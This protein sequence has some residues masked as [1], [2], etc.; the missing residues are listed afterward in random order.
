MAMQEGLFTLSKQ[1][2]HM[3]VGGQGGK[4]KGHH[5]YNISHLF[6]GRQGKE[7][8]PWRHSAPF[9]GQSF[10]LLPMRTLPFPSPRGTTYLR[11]PDHP[12]ACPVLPPWKMWKPL[13]AAELLHPPLLVS[14]LSTAHTSD[15]QTHLMLCSAANRSSRQAAE[16]G[17]AEQ[18]PS[19]Q[20]W[21]TG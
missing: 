5:M 8:Q 15:S 11:G 4:R 14:C 19:S 6:Y 9:Q 12:T 2:V 13:P 1:S 21:D 10:L 3:E 18:L 16:E 20:S 7:R 17:T